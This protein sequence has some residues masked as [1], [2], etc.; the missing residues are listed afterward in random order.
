MSPSVEPVSVRRDHDDRVDLQEPVEDALGAKVR[1]A[2]RPHGTERS[3]CQEGDDGLRDVRQK[4]GDALARPDA[5]IAQR[6][7]KR[8]D[9]AAELVV[10][11]GADGLAFLHEEHGGITARSTP[12]DLFGVVE[13]RAREPVGRRHHSL[14]QHRARSPGSNLVVVPYRSP[15]GFQ[16]VRRPPPE[17][18]VVVETQVAAPGQPVEKFSQGA[19][20]LIAIRR[21]AQ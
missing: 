2:R 1:S 4:S 20:Q 7:R 17:L 13:L 12:Q 15:E 10:A 14:G 3:R 5:E 9:L 8:A 11:D 16:L 6:G 19:G 18:A 21:W